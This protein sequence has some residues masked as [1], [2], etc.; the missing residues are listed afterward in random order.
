MI[1][2]QPKD[3]FNSLLAPLEEDTTTT[4]TTTSDDDDEEFEPMEID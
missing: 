2:Y 3:V 1:L 4:T